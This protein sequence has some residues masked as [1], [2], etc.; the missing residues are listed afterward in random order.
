[1]LEKCSLLD[2]QFMEL[3]LEG[4]EIDDAM[5]HETL[6]QGTIALKCVPVL[7]GTALRN[8]GIQPIVD[9]IVRYF[10]SPLDIPPVQGI[11]PQ[12]G[13]MEQREVSDE[14]DLAALAFKIV[15]DEGR[16]LTY[17]RI[18]SGTIKVGDDIYNVNL[19][20]RGKGIKNLP[21]AC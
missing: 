1:M 17:I 6:R 21:D 3:Y 9:S 12:T 14:E 2:D 18:Y 11:N 19:G 5:I 16:K 10:P 15:L 7:C 4:K 8:K 13:Q 20:K